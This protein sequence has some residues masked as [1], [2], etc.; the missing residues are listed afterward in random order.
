MKSNLDD[1]VEARA[2]AIELIKSLLQGN[3]SPNN[4]NRIIQTEF[5]GGCTTG[6]H[7]IAYNRKI[8][9][10]NTNAIRHEKK[11]GGHTFN[12]KDLIIEIVFTDKQMCL[13]FK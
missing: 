10:S 4:L 8:S 1:I 11:A 7:Y 5:W 12:I 9:V 6:L 3:H 2:V 13:D